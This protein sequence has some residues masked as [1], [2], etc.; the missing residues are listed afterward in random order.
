MILCTHIEFFDQLASMSYIHQLILP[1]DEEWNG[2]LISEG[3]TEN[4]DLGSSLTV[5][6]RLWDHMQNSLF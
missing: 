6:A 4:G 3:S 5:T 1:A 2:K